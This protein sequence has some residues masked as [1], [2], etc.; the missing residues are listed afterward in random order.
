MHVTQYHPAC[1]VFQL[2]QTEKAPAHAVKCAKSGG[3]IF[4][5]YFYVFLFAHLQHICE[6]LN[7]SACLS[8]VAHL[9]VDSQLD[10]RNMRSVEGF[11]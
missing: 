8:E 4:N 1:S 3:T 6:S 5:S 7:G 9:L 2:P 11:L 10:M